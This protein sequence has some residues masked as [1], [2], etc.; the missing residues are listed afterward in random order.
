MPYPTPLPNKS[1][2]ESRMTF[3]ANVHRN[4]VSTG[5][6]DEKLLSTYYDG[7]WVYF[8]ILDYTSD[9]QWATVADSF[10]AFYRDQ[11]INAQTPHGAVPGYWNFTHGETES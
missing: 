6:Y 11:Y 4:D 9:P 1:D 8:R 5:T 2:W 10:V 3:Y 7:G